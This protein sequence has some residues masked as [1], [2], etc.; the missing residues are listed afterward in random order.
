MTNVYIWFWIPLEERFG[1]D[2]MFIGH[3]DT[4]EEARENFIEQLMEDEIF[5]AVYEA[6]NDEQ[7]NLMIE[8]RNAK[9]EYLK[10]R[11]DFCHDNPGKCQITYNL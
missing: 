10:G 5:D 7:K 2:V 6:T 1:R 4:E 11:P 8:R 9:V 3:Y